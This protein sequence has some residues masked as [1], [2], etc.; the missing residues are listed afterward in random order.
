MKILNQAKGM[1]T[2]LL[3][4]LLLLLLT[5]SCSKDN[6][7]PCGNPT[8]TYYRSIDTTNIP[9]K[10]G[11]SF[12]YKDKDG[13]LI[14]ARIIKDTLFYNCILQPISNPN[15]GTQNSNC[16]INK[17]Y[18]FDTLADVR[19]DTEIGRLFIVFNNSNFNVRTA[20]LINPFMKLYPYYDSILISNRSFYN[21]RLVTNA[22]NDTLLINYKEGILKVINSQNTYSIQ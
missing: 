17:Q 2:K 7:N 4:I 6:G 1:T 13:N 20:P 15:C 5:Q 9:Y 11:N 8:S 10:K 12:T 19:L 3:S 22:L 21:V 16:Y 18:Y 14:S